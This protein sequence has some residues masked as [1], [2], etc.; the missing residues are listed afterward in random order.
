MNQFVD[1]NVV[2]I[3]DGAGFG[4]EMND[5]VVQQ[6]LRPRKLAIF[7][8]ESFEWIILKSGIVKGVEADRIEH[9]ELYADSRKYMSWEQYFTEVLEQTTKDSQFMKYKK[10]KLADYYKQ[11]QNAKQILEIAKGIKFEN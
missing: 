6:T 1:K 2:V 4:S 9:P 10:S 8:P 11:E 3:A 5:V 7:L